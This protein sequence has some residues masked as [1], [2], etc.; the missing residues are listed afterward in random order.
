MYDFDAMADRKHALIV[1]D[2][3]TQRKI[4]A[5]CL[6]AAG[7]RVTAVGRIAQ[8]LAL[9][10]GGERIDLFILDRNLPDGDGL[11]VC[12]R[13][14]RDSRTRLAPVIVL[15]SMSEFK[16]Q[17][18]SYK[19]GADLFLPKPVEIKK[20]GAYVSALASR[21]TSKGETTETLSCGK[22]TL[23]PE[24]RG[25]R[26]GSISLEG[27]AERPFALLYLLAAR[28]GRPVPAKTI[29]QKLWGSAV[30]D[31]EVAVTVSRLRRRLGPRLAGL[32]RFVSGA[33]YSINPDFTP[34][35][36]A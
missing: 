10:D 19:S 20:L 12:R 36:R 1:E 9:I 4:I 15:T 21:E 16:E 18:Q 31:K 13:L 35:P 6:G 25:V 22:L 8:A 28:Q 33:G 23:E 24:S 34:R 29:L 17:L 30:R 26:V 14:K 27:L 11:S 5:A 7:L 2:D 32:I 3:E